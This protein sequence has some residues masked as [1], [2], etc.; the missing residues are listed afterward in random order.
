[1]ANNTRLAVLYDRLGPYHH[2]RMNA[3]GRRVDLTAVEFSAF[4]ETYAW[5]RIK[6]TG[7]Y[8]RVTLFSDKPI[9][10]HSSATVANRVNS[11]LAEIDPQVVVIPG[12]DAPAALIALQWCLETGTPTVLLSDSQASDRKRVWWKE[13]SKGRIVRLH[14]SGFVGGA[15]HVAYLGTLGMS[16]SRICTGCD[17]V[18]NAFFAAEAEAARQDE[19]T[20]ERLVLPRPYF[21]TSGR[22]IEKKN[23]P[24]L[25]HAYADYRTN[26]GDSAWDLVLIGDG[27]LKPRLMALR[28][29]L[30]L[31]GKVILP[32][33]KQYA[34]LPAYY[35]LAGAF[36]HVSTSETWGLVVNEAMACG[37]PVI[38]SSPCGC[39]PDLVR[40]G[41]NGFV[42]NPY[43]R[44]ELSLI[45]SHVSGANCNRTA[46]GEAGRA[47]IGEF[48]PDS[49]AVN[50]CKAAV[51]AL[52]VPRPGFGYVDQVFLWY[53]IHRRR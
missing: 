34:E 50:L 49:Y 36:I 46:I 37:L 22:F 40:H 13:S 30:G 7:A 29:E 52:K 24:L 3:L 12:W 19:T 21:L 2:A 14:S 10:M 51:M 44:E 31:D 48:S 11:V 41:H 43:D 23:L 35:G 9:G 26:A 1:M 18:D 4:D 28:K 38:V 32:G 33:F 15:P 8:R 16:E 17:V 6:D 45:L 53:L 47:I 20:R 42:F 5:D 39:V 25:L 27:P